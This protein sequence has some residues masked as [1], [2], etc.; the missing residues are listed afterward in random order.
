MVNYLLVRG[1]LSAHPGIGLLLGFAGAGAI[2][3]GG[4]LLAKFRIGGALRYAGQH[5][6]VIYLTF[7]LPM[8]AAQKLLADTGLIGDVGT[9]S[10]M[11]L[12]IGVTGP[13]LFHRIIKRTPLRLLYERPA[14]AALP[15]AR[16]TR[17]HARSASIAP[18]TTL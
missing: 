9:A 8:K 3:T 16:R 18:S 11:V 10:L 13:L 5:S 15:S 14:W 2:I 17:H 7:F 1:G 12:I 6:I 4:A